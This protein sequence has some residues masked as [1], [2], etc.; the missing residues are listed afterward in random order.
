MNTEYRMLITIISWCV[1]FIYVQLYNQQQTSDR[2]WGCVIHSHFCELEQIRDA[3]LCVRESERERERCVN[4]SFK[5]CK[6]TCLLWLHSEGCVS[7]CGSIFVCV[8]KTETNEKTTK[9][10]TKTATCRV[11][12]HRLHSTTI[13]LPK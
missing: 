6:K 11:Q 8:T 5:T 4:P 9:R 7:V 13:K 2:V 3:N 12:K 10:A 1:H